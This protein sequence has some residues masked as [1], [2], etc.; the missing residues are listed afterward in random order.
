MKFSNRLEIGPALSDSLLTCF[1]SST[2]LLSSG[3]L[4]TGDVGLLMTLLLLFSEDP[5]EL[6]APRPSSGTFPWDR[7]VET[8]PGPGFSV[9]GSSFIPLSNSFLVTENFSASVTLSIS[10]SSPFGVLSVFC[11]SWLF[12]LLRLVLWVLTGNLDTGDTGEDA[13][14]L[15]GVAGRPFAGKCSLFC[16]PDC[17]TA[18]L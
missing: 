15:S 8:L 4:L 17:Q 6:W 5:K 11:S 16:L 9:A 18:S 2:S 10:T 3:A 14:W 13:S 1:E 7:W 12:A